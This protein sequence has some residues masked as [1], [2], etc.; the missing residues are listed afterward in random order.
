[1]ELE[2]G[3]SKGL[4]VSVFFICFWWC[5]I[6]T[7]SISKRYSHTF[8]SLPPHHKADWCSRLGSTIHATMIVIGV[9]YCAVNQ[10]WTDTWEPDGEIMP[11]IPL[12]FCFST[13]YF[14][15]DLLIIIIWQVS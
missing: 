11:L 9:L 2:D 8:L 15:C 13:A 12:C 14:L 1:M 6:M 10:R 3:W 7:W 5:F 4:V